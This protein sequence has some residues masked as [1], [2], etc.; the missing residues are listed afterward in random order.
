MY[1]NKYSITNLIKKG[2][3]LKAKNADYFFLLKNFFSKKKETAAKQ[4]PLQRRYPS[5]LSHSIA[6]CVYAAAPIKSA[7]SSNFTFG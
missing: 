2:K 4:F 1:Y 6:V 5:F 7:P 3:C